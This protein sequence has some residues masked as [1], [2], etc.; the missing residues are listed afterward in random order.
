MSMAVRGRSSCSADVTTAQS[1]SEWVPTS[2][3]RGMDAASESI[4]MADA[5]VP[6]PES[7]ATQTQI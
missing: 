2:I 3:G 1:T 5:S 6:G 7:P 4:S